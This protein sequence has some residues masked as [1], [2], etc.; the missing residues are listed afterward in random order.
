MKKTLLAIGVVLAGFSASA[1]YFTASSA[2]EFANFTLIDA[3]TNT[4]D[5][6][7]IA[8]TT[9]PME[10][11]GEVLMSFSFV[12]GAG[13][14][15]NNLIVTPVINLTGVTGTVAVSFKIGSP[16]TTASGWYEEFLSVY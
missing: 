9:L 1:Q 4:W 8:G 15:P 14:T 13:I 12:G 5:I 3:D 6:Y 7:D 2:A 11:Q 16:E 10:A